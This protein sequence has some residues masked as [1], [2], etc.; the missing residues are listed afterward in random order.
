MSLEP[1]WRPGGTPANR[2]RNC[3]KHVTDA[4]V[5]GYSDNDDVL[6]HC[7]DCPDLCARDMRN[8]AGKN[9]DYDPARDRVQSTRSGHYPMDGDPR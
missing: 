9:P 4:L 3:G 8:G 7:P 5:R 1:R 6:W 2:C